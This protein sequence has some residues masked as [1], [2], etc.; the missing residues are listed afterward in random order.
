M[1]WD[2]NVWHTK[3]MEIYIMQ[4]TNSFN[5]TLATLLAKQLY[6]SNDIQRSDADENFSILLFKFCHL[7]EALILTKASEH[8]PWM[9][10]RMICF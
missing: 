5:Y 8:L 4:A 9:A 2:R 6:V 3:I 7:L 10:D 1:E